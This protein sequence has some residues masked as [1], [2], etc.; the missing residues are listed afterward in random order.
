MKRV[1]VL[2]KG[3]LAIRIANYFLQESAHYTLVGVVQKPDPTPY[4]E[5]LDSWA[6]GAGVPSHGHHDVLP[7]GLDFIWMILYGRLLKAPFLS[8]QGRVLNIHS[9][10]LPEFRGVGT[11]NWALERGN[12]QHGLAIHEVFTGVDDGPVLA[13][14]TYPIY[15]ELDEVGDLYQRFFDFGWVLF[16][17]VVGRVDRIQPLEQDPSRA[18][19]FSRGDLDKLKARRGWSRVGR[20]VSSLVVKESG[21]L[22]PLKAPSQPFDDAPLA[23]RTPRRAT[24]VEAL[25]QK[26]ANFRTEESLHRGLRFRPRR[27]DLFVATYP[28]CGTTWLLQIVHALR[29]GGDTDFQ[30]IGEVIPWL[31]SAWDL[32][33]RPP[34]ANQQWAPRAYK[35]HL[36]FDRLPK[37]GR[38]IYVVRDPKDVVLSMYHF[39]EGWIFEPAAITLDEFVTE[40]FIVAAGIQ[41]YWDHLRSWWPTLGAENVLWL[42]YEELNRD[43]RGGIRQVGRFMGIDMSMA[44]LDRVTELASFDYM[45]SQRGKFDNEE[46]HHYRDPAMGI[47]PGRVS[48]MVRA[49]RAVTGSSPLS[50]A[51]LHALDVAWHRHL[52]GIPGLDSYKA[53]SQRI[54]S[55]LVARISNQ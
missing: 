47:P 9:G 52:A 41:C 49:G 20:S 44:L 43:L 13:Q 31:E 18:T 33:Q 5:R 40:V 3:A 17:H 16:C 19:Y 10:P 23:A 24:S 35:T 6:A 48:G 42:S 7:A 54:Q 36:A 2:G 46:V 53:L 22:R 30:K 55:D 34:E 15:P 25:R 28:K 8:Q 26:L 38:A 21:D 1:A 37:G 50:P 14:S 51:S 27:D 39:F 45:K 32:R 12:R 4:L 29:S 11:I